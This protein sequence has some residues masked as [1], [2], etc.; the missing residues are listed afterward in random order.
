MTN[1]NRVV[2]VLHVVSH[3]VFVVAPHRRPSFLH[4]YHHGAA[5]GEGP[6]LPATSMDASSAAA[7]ANS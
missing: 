1:P 7:I 5:D 2:I 4:P 6:A 3:S